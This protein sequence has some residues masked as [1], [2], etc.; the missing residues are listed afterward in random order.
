[1]QIGTPVYAL[2]GN[3]V[4]VICDIASG[5][6]PITIKWFINGVEDTSFGNVSTITI[7]DVDPDDDRD[8]YMCRAENEIGFDE[9]TTTINIF[10]EC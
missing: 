9:V 3:D 6:H 7:T 4:T 8:I 2:V 1:V 5:T 10:G